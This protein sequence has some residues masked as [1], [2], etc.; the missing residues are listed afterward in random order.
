[1]EKNN[2]RFGDF[3]IATD[4]NQCLPGFI[5]DDKD[6]IE[7]RTDDE[8]VPALDDQGN[9][10]NVDSYGYGFHAGGYTGEDPLKIMIQMTQPSAVED[11]APE[12]RNAGRFVRQS[13]G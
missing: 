12:M 4:A 9:Q 6:T 10:K 1:L 3:F 8:W 2:K 7:D 5:W 13:F 11:S